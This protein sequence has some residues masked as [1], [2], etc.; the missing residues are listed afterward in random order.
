M[1]VLFIPSWTLING[2]L[3]LIYGYFQAF[4]RISSLKIPANHRSAMA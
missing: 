1:F 4:P 3:R 2:H